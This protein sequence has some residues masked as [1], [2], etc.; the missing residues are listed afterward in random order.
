MKVRHF[1]SADY[2]VMPWKNGRGETLQLLILPEGSEFPPDSSHDG[3]LWRI[4][5]A[6]VIETSEFSQFPGYDRLLAIWE[7]KGLR[8][9][10][11]GQKSDVTLLKNQVI[12]FSGDD[13]TTAHL[14]ADSV[15]DFGVIFKRGVVA[16]TLKA[17][18]FARNGAKSTASFSHQSGKPGPGSVHSR[19]ICY[20][21]CAEG[22]VQI[23]TPLKS[24]E[25]QTEE[26]L[27]LEESGNRSHDE[28]DVSRSSGDQSGPLIQFESLAPQ[29]RIF[30]VVISIL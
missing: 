17:F 29:S 2:R 14:L 1:K 9:S 18:S 16:A 26:M 10:S 5:A 27:S 13:A 8:L 12:H 19:S 11:S 24:F 30:Q 25:L 23:R 15:R 28:S 22:R 4:S 6:P 7:G 3:F 21:F 20:L